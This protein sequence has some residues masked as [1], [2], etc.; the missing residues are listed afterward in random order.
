MGERLSLFHFQFQRKK[1]YRDVAAKGDIDGEA[2]ARDWAKASWAW[3]RNRRE[4]RHSHCSN[5]RHLVGMN[6]SN[7]QHEF[8]RPS[9]AVRECCVSDCTVHGRTGPFLLRISHSSL[10]RLTSTPIRLSHAYLPRHMTGFSPFG[11]IR[12][13]QFCFAHIF[14]LFLGTR[15][16]PQ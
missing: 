12:D 6:F 11:H 2:S 3:G 1:S 5:G 14:I 8:R 15:P 9:Y 7:A 4:M 13:I 10:P 16:L